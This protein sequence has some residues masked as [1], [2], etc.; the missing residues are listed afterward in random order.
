[1]NLTRP[2]ST[3]LN[4]I[5]TTILLI[6]VWRIDAQSKKARNDQALFFITDEFDHWPDFPGSTVQQVEEIEKELKDRYGFSTEIVRNANR[7][8]IL[9]KLNEYEK[10]SF[11][12]YDQLII[13]F[14][15]HGYYDE[16]QIGA[17][18]P[19]NG[20][21]EDPYYESWIM[22]PLLET[23]V[24]RIPCEHVL[25]SIDACYS[26]TFGGSRG[27]PTKP[28]WN[29]SEN[30]HTRARSILEYKSRLY[31][32]SGG[33]VRT[34][35]NSE[36]AD[37][38]L[39]ALRVRNQDGIMS[40][41]EFFS[42]LSEANP[43]PLFGEF[44]SHD[45]GGNFVFLNQDDCDQE[46]NEEDNTAEGIFN[47]AEINDIYEAKDYE[48]SFPLFLKYKDHPEFTGEHMKN[49]GRSYDLGHGTEI[50]Y[51]EALIWYQKA[52][53]KNNAHAM[54]NIG[55]MHMQSRFS[56]ST[57]E[58]GI[59][60]IRRAVDRGSALAMSNYGYYLE[61]GFGVEKN[62]EEAFNWYSKS[63][64]LGNSNG[65]YFLGLL[66]Y[67]GVYVSQNFKKAEEYLVQAANLGSSDAMSW[68]GDMYHRND[69]I[70]KDY[71]RALAWYTKADSIG[72]PYASLI[73]G[74]W[75]VS[76]YNIRKTRDYQRGVTHYKKA[77]LMGDTTAQSR[78]LNIGETWYE[79]IEGAD[80]D[81]DGVHDDIDL[82]PRV[83]GRKENKGCPILRKTYSKTLATRPD[84]EEA[85]YKFGIPKNRFYQAD[86]YLETTRIDS[87]TFNR[88]ETQVLSKDL[89]FY[90]GYSLLY[91]IDKN[92]KP[93]H[94]LYFNNSDYEDE[95]IIPIDY[96]ND[97]I[98]RLNQTFPINLNEEN[99]Y[100]Y[101]YFFFSSVAG[102]HGRFFIVDTPD[103]LPKDILK[104]CGDEARKYFEPIDL[105]PTD[106]SSVFYSS[107]VT[108]LFKG[109]MFTTELIIDTNTGNV[110]LKNE[111]MLEPDC[112]F[113]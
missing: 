30:C 21:L 12:K 5:L 69:K 102:R 97:P 74:D 28:R 95:R 75:F 109:S 100:D 71:D 61:Y 47:I 110:E 56:Y 19:K 29:V 80:A 54:N 107:K 108:M 94:Y 90:P 48:R 14:S 10:K 46:N 92:N 31:V 83:K 67:R 104:T 72:N 33:K 18:V 70:E 103:Q 23:M 4:L 49:L 51:G 60:W 7:R 58:L 27:K 41:H 25:L 42:V 40:F 15:Q 99:I 93:Y 39:E 50:D 78:L 22:Y 35:T 76:G 44:G 68:L 13:Y 20:Q 87:I 89:P 57:K 38:F 98:F 101:T 81:S 8:E 88:S 105:K 91:L 77:A 82:C 66:Y 113:K 59:K 52:V 86:F 43:S 64:E 106:S 62:L 26:G 73:L 112:S 17:L 63:A 16:G 84:F 37:K 32:T 3:H 79:A 34:P 1:M 55:I 65:L 111:K 24:N 2:T 85:I 96:K 36:F 9:D 53:A 6:S 11:G 45:Q